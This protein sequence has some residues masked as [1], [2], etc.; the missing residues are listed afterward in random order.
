MSGV[1][2]EGG[3]IPLVVFC[4]IRCM[5][6]ENCSRF[7]LPVCLVSASPL[8]TSALVTLRKEPTF[9]SSS[10]THGQ[11]VSANMHIKQYCECADNR[12]ATN[13]YF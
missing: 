4:W 12:A 3:S 8:Q 5:A 10:L 1:N 7:S 13:E 11:C 9:H 2:V 6:K